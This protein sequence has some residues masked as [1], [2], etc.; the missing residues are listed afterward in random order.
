MQ[1]FNEEA[2]SQWYMV[3]IIQIEFDINCFVYNSLIFVNSRTFSTFIPLTVLSFAS[4]GDLARVRLVH[5]CD[6]RARLTEK[7]HELLKPNQTI[8]RDHYCLQ[9]MHLTQDLSEIPPLYKKRQ[10]KVF[11]VHD[12]A[13]HMKL[14]SENIS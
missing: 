5:N 10:D 3:R 13:L 11:L 12:N 6:M 9:L 1:S 7:Y 4:F 8:K 2:Y 14:N